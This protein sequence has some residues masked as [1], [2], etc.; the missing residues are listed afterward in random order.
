MFLL[1]NMFNEK[2]RFAKWK[3]T[4]VPEWFEMKVTEV[5]EEYLPF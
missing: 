5:V 1:F 3:A 4:E 2:M